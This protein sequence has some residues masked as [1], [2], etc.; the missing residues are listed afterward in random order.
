MSSQVIHCIGDSHASFFSG[1][2]DTRPARPNSTQDLLPSFRAYHLGAVLAYSLCDYGSTMQGKEKFLKL[3]GEIPKGSNLLLCFGEIDCRVHLIKQAQKQNKELG[4]VVTECVRRYLAFVAEIKNN[5]NVLVWGVIP[6][7]PSEK[8][9]DLRYPHFGSGLERNQVSIIFNSKLREWA[10]K[11]GVKFISI[12]NQLVKADGLTDGK[13]YADNVHLSQRAMP[14]AIRQFQSDFPEL[15]VQFFK[16]KFLLGLP[17]KLQFLL[18]KSQCDA[19]TMFYFFVRW[20]RKVIKKIIL[21][22]ISETAWQKIRK[23]G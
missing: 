1:R 22:V 4:E 17:S 15:G 21:L 5:Y 12:F 9:L 14:L 20:T 6:S 19:Q 11:M 2:N 8:V 7:T 13:F 16:N 18:F 10:D 3:L 23:I